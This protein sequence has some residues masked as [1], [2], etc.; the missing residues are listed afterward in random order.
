MNIP[1]MNAVTISILG[2]KSSGGGRMNIV[3]SPE[4]GRIPMK[5]EKWNLYVT[6][7]GDFDFKG[8]L[9]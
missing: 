7:D 5:G 6:E 1:A 9:R 4:P 2:R 8:Q 3:Q